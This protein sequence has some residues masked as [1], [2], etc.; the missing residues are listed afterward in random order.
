MLTKTWLRHDDH[1]ATISGSTIANAGIRLLEKERLM[2]FI[3][4]TRLK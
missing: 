2:M 1:W 4:H 3:F